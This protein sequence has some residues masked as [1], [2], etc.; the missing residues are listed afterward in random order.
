MRRAIDLLPDHCSQKVLFSKH[1][2]HHH[3]KI[4]NFVI[5]NTNENHT[6]FP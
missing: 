2:I 4:V 6:I 5:I 1:F 3:P